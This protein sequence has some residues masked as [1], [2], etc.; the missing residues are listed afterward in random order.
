MKETKIAKE[1]ID[2]IATGIALLIRSSIFQVNKNDKEVFAEE[3]ERL[4]GDKLK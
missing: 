3:Y 2:L 1:K 4:F